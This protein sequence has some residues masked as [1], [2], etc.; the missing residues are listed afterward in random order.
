MAWANLPVPANDAER[1]QRVEKAVRLI[2]EKFPP[3]ASKLRL[4]CR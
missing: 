4:G 2:L 1:Q 3:P